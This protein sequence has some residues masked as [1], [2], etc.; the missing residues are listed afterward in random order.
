MDINEYKVYM[1]GFEDRWFQTFDDAKKGRIGLV[2]SLPAKMTNYGEILKL[3][4]QGAGIFMCPNPIVGG[5][6]KE[7]NVQKIVY[8]FADMDKEAGTKEEQAK[9]I[10]NAPLEPTFTVESRNGY[11]VYY[12][13]DITHEN[14]DRIIRGI[15]QYF[16]GD[17]ALLSKNEVLRVPSF[18]HQKN[19]DDKFLIKMHTQSGNKYEEKELISAFPYVPPIET[20][21]ARHDLFDDDLNLVKDIPVKEVLAKLNVVVKNN[22]IWENG[23]ETSAHINVS[24]NY[25]NRFSGKQGAGST[26]D[27][28]MGYGNMELQ[29]AI[30]WLRK[31]FNIQSKPMQNKKARIVKINP[32]SEIFQRLSNFKFEQLKTNTFLDSHRLFIR[33]AVTRLGGYSNMGKS[34]LAY[35]WASLLLEQGYKGNV[36]S[37]E[38][39]GEIVCAR[40][41]QTIDQIPFLDIIDHKKK[42]ST[43]AMELISNLNIFDIREHRNSIIEIESRIKSTYPDFV[44]IDFCQAMKD[45]ANS[46]DEYS[47][48]TNWAFE[49]QEIAQRYNCAIIDLSQ[50][51]ND[52]IRNDYANAG[53]IPY[54]G[55]G[56]LY[57]SA[58]MGI[59]IRRDKDKTPDVMEVCVRKHKYNK[60]FDFH[61]AVDWLT[62]QFRETEKIENNYI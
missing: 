18:Y 15:V 43:K 32:P 42:P 54:K 26:I 44:V 49:I 16:D 57:F 38:V 28:V 8:A 35:N 39:V 45:K 53:F 30:Q 25:V 23:E 11:H 40:M 5:S 59:M 13:C 41:T 33:G 48:M 60:T 47:A 56:A 14:W 6:R 4:E 19:P 7:E 61:L 17:E 50:L 46:K 62:C 20:F 55:S 10:K 27:V 22:T 31:E 3:N 52:S 34:A 1:D 12:R 37:S 58:D 9:R 24:G 21:Q 2:K 29:E 51:S 36:Y